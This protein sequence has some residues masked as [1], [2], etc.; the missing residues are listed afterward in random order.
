MA[1]LR[2]DGGEL[3]LALSEAEKLESVH[4]DLRVPLAAVT[5]VEVLEDAHGPVGITAGVKVGTR[6]PGVIE[7]GIIRG[8]TKKLFAVVHHD[9]PR[10]VRVRLSGVPWDEWIVGCTDPEAVAARLREG[11][12]E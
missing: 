5:G 3:T 9:T 2:V 8:A 1:E 6:I 12:E 10:G 4:R 7:V 11:T